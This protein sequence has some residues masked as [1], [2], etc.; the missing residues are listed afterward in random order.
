MKFIAL[1]FLLASSC[2][3]ASSETIIPPTDPVTVHCQQKL[4]DHIFIARSMRAGAKR[5]AFE[6]F[7]KSA[8]NLTPEHLEEVLKLINEAYAAKDA[9]EWLNTYWLPCMA[10]K[11]I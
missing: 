4:N 10:E 1:V 6:A 9:T 2:L 8:S 7:A 11:E 3:A 5:G